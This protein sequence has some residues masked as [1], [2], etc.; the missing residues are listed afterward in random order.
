MSDKLTEDDKNMIE[1][2]VFEKGDIE[3]WVSWEKRKPVI[4]RE[5]PHLIAA[6][7]N[8]EI[9]E[10]TLKAIVRDINAN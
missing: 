3:R 4:E 1:Y 6:I 2:F 5:L 9:A 7:K 8:L 10:K